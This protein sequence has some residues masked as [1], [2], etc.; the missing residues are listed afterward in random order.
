M[1]MGKRLSALVLGMTLGPHLLA[2]HA[3]AA[4]PV[5]LLTGYTLTSWATK[6]GLPGTVRA[7]AQ[8]DDGYLWLGTADGLVRFDGVRFVP[9]PTYSTTPLPE[10]G[11]GALLVAHDGSLWAGFDEIGIIR[12]QD[13][14]AQRFGEV[15]G[16]GL[17]SVTNLAEDRQRNIWS[18]SSAGLFRFAGGHW[19]K[20]GDPHGFPDTAAFSLF[21]DETGALFVGT[22]DGVFRLRPG[23][24]RFELATASTADVLGLTGDAVGHFWTTDPVVGFAPLRTDT[25]PT[26]TSTPGRGSR[27]LHDRHGNLWVGTLGQGLWRVRPAREDRDAAIEQV[28]VA[29]GL[30]SNRVQALF[31]DRDGTV[32]AG[33]FEGLSQLT[34]HRVTPL[35]TLG[36]IA[37]VATTPDG[38]VWVAT[39]EELIRFPGKTAATGGGGS[40]VTMPGITALAADPDGVVWAATDT[41]LFRISGDGVASPPI[42]H[43]PPLGRITSLAADPR[44][45]LWIFDAEQ[46]LFRWHLGRIEPAGAGLDIRHARITFTHV[47]RS[48]RF[49]LAASGA[50]LVVVSADGMV[51]ANEPDNRFGSEP[52]NTLYEDRTGTIFLGSDQ[53][54]TWLE[55]GRPHSVNGNNGLPSD[56]ILE[57]VEDDEGHLWLATG[58]GIVRIERPQLAMAAEN[59]AHQIRYRLYDKSD[60]LAG[61]PVRFANRGGLRAGDGSLWFVTGRGL[62][63]IEPH[64]LVAQPPA[65]VQIEGATADGQ[66]VSPTE[67]RLTAGT[68]RLQID[69]TVLSLASPSKTRFRY[70]LE[71]FDTDWIQA[72]AGRQA[73]YTNLPPQSY[74]FDVVANNDEGTWN[75]P[76]AA[77]DFS[78]RPVFYQTWWFMALSL[79]TLVGVVG[80]FWQL[81]LRHV[82]R[83]FSLVLGERVRVSH[84]LH[85]TLL[86]NLVGVALQI[87]VASKRIGSSPSEARASLARMREQVEEYIRETRQSIWNLRSPALETRKLGQALRASGEQSAA[88]SASSFEF[89]TSGA[90]GPVS[91]DV[92]HELLRIGQEA[93]HNAVRHARASRIHAELHYDDHTVRLRISDDGHGFDPGTLPAES[94]AHYGIMTMEE[95][96]V[97]IGGR[98]TLTS[99]EGAG[100]V[101]EVA[102]P[103]PGVRH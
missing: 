93:I 20:L 10:E 97:E 38:D 45:G 3:H 13:G 39:T 103:V 70:R 43:E 24:A 57:I 54:V 61:L 32:W 86:Q 16:V 94:D 82:R 1:G 102:V 49:W 56:L 74:R 53:G 64:T 78:I 7:I 100:T 21:V 31:E 73:L 89:T 6:D 71:G 52:Y 23:A 11:V 72:G 4:E 48:G 75:L 17:G 9:W 44:D 92:N 80:A 59:P 19:Q 18:A 63:V 8:T 99:A 41:E 58:A 76:G 79:V 68:T 34:P 42:P 36:L 50:P 14:Q 60:G 84:E 81:H 98:F 51:R 26:R 91:P 33:T 5:G 65:E 37:A 95:R 12:L 88:W 62:T 40:R 85:D 101:V 29:T 2:I 55:G 15:D 96:A 87:E 83:E 66:P 25:T 30:P 67:Q 47:D 27:V 35:M 69:Y 90:P 22:S 77:W 46:G 28:T